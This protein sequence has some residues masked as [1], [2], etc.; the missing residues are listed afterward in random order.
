MLAA[1]IAI[2]ASDESS[3]PSAAPATVALQS[4]PAIAQPQLTANPAPAAPP[5]ITAPVPAIAAISPPPL[6]APA[7]FQIPPQRQCELA[8]RKLYVAGNGVVRISAGE[9]VS[10]PVTLGPYPQTVA[11]PAARPAPGTEA[12]QT[13]LVEGSA[14]TMVMTS[15]LPGFRRVFNGL[16][17]SSS[18][19][20]KWQPLGNC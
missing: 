16:R 5:A 1:V 14:S 12:I 20:V 3:Q 13:I 8:Q 6:Q 4:A 17:G 2:T 19:T 7:T 11:F 18:F 10:A 9:Y 15:D